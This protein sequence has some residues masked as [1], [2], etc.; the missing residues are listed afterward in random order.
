MGR[1]HK[2]QWRDLCPRGMEVVAQRLGDK[3]TTAANRYLRAGEDACA[4]RSTSQLGDSHGRNL[5]WRDAWV[6]PLRSRPEKGGTGPLRFRRSATR[7]L[8]RGAHGGARRF[9]VIVAVLAPARWHLLCVATCWLLTSCALTATCK[10]LTSQETLRRPS[11]L[12]IARGDRGNVVRHDEAREL[13]PGSTVGRL[14][15]AA[16]G[17]HELAPG[18]PTRSA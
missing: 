18:T 17:L 8:L 6:K 11:S 5:C 14:K 2:V 13:Q 12:T 3:L 10:S 15:H 4:T 9:R 7:R 16:D 1:V